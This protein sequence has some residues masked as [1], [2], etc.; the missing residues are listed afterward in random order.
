MN[1]PK[2]LIVDDDP[3]VL[4]TISM[5]LSRDNIASAK[6]L[7]ADAIRHANLNKFDCILLDIW[8]S[9][10]YGEES[11]EILASHNYRG[12]VIVLSGAPKDE[13]NAVATK[14]LRLGLSVIGYLRKPVNKVEL[15]RVLALN[16][17]LQFFLESA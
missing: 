3:V 1:D 9:D 8:L 12:S 5:M 17:R 2:I 4:E 7:N 11:L 15:N 14:G 10:S 13:I 16:P 6:A